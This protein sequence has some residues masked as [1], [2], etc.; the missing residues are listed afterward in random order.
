MSD[1]RPTLEVLVLTYKLTAVMV[2]PS[3][4][5]RR[6]PDG[7]ISGACDLVRILTLADMFMF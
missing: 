5:C 4:G 6:D 1:I 7:K 3:P 2:I